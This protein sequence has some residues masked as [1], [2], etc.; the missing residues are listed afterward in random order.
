LEKETMLREGEEEEEEEEEE[1]KGCSYSM[2][3]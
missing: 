2:I 1:E 3:L